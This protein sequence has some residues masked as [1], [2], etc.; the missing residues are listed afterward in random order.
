M[1]VFKRVELQSEARTLPAKYYTSPEIFAKER[2][3]I[4]GQGWLYV[5]R[6]DS[7]SESGD[8]F[9]FNIFNESLIVVRGPDERIRALFNVCRHRGT[10]ICEETGGKFTGAI[11]C[12]YHAWTYGLDGRLMA[13]R[14]MQ[15][16]PGFDKSQWPLHE[17]PLAEWEGFL[18]VSLSAKPE[19]FAK[20]FTPL[21]NR[22]SKWNIGG[23]RLAKRITY[24][25]RCNWKLVAQNY[26][27]CYHCPVIH[28]QLDKL[29]PWD[30]GR[31][32]LGEG[33]FLGGFMTL[34][35][36]GGS[37]T[38]TGHTERPP[39]GEVD[40]EELDRIYYYSIFPSMLLSLHPDYV[41]A[42][43]LVPLAVDRVHIECDWLFDPKTMARPD[44]DPSDAVGF[45]D[46][47][48]RQDWK[49]CELSQAGIE[50]RAYVPGPYSSN[51]GILHA[52]DKHYLSVIE[53]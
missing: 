44:F 39:V 50:S 51:E 21:I 29:S 19:P 20:A 16:T 42:H 17:A 27:E 41:M 5:G 25:L 53:S 8:Y 40:G 48:N 4:F 10:R 7:L 43:R 47:T 32:D 2:D 23:L 12:P 45:W 49:V 38:L 13:A 52:Y 35:N 18:F 1:R 6:A 9:T 15:S 3:R 37:M 24:D 14:N 30:S 22:F 11:Q 26:S 31:N 33:P 34:R 46:M 36:P 28:P